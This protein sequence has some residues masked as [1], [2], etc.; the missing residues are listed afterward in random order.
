[1]LAF[2]LREGPPRT[3]PPSRAQ[4]LCLKAN[5]YGNQPTFI[6][7]GNDKTIH[8]W[9]LSNYAQLA[10]LEGHAEAVTVRAAARAARA[11]RSCPRCPRR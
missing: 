7:A 5:P 4:I 3:L 1:M 2:A 8:I 6:T 11:A 9:A 10:R